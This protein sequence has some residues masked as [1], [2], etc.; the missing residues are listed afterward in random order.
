MT[1]APEYGAIYI[2]VVQSGSRQICE[3]AVQH[4]EKLRRFVNT[5]CEQCAGIEWADVMVRAGG[6][7]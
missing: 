2:E 6:R 1:L 7:F 5:L 3:K 4:M